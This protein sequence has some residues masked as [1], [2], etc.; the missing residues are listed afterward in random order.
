MKKTFFS[1]LFCLS[2]ISVSLAAPIRIVCMGNSITQGNINKTTN[3]IN[4]M[5]YRFALW[6]KLDSAGIDIDMVGYTNLWFDEKSNNLV[7][8]PVSKY[9][10][11]VFDRDHDAYYGINSTNLLNGD[12]Y[13]GWTGAALPSLVVRLNSYTADIALLHIGTNDADN[14]VNT[15]VSNIKAIID[16]LRVK[17]P[18]IVVFVAKTITTWKA[19]NAKVDQIAIDKNTVQSPVIAVDLATGFINDTKLAGCMTYDWVHPNPLGQEF[20]AKRWFEAI[21]KQLNLNTGFADNPSSTAAVEVYPRISNGNFTISNCNKAFVQ[22]FNTTGKIMKS[23]ETNVVGTIQLDL[24]DLNNG[25]YIVQ[26][27]QNGKRSAKKIVIK[28]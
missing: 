3:V 20:M 22:V 1:L 16:A 5:S 7:T 17:N 21:K 24:A 28:K 4:Q 14:I 8:P 18:N 27:N 25:L 6:Q 26:I 15:T 13:V 23:I 19:I 12:S 9:T 10:G 11:H 2:T